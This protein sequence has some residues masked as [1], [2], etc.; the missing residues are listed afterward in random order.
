MSEIYILHTSTNTE[1]TV[2]IFRNWVFEGIM[3]N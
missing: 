3:S 1:G 2:E